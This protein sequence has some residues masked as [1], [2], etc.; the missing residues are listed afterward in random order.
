MGYDRKI[1][2]LSKAIFERKLFELHE[3]IG[4]DIMELA[5]IVDSVVSEFTAAKLVYKLIGYQ[6]L[7]QGW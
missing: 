6:A 1:F 2:V 4:C 3:V 7:A 5:P